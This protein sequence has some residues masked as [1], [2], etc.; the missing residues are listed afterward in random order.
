MKFYIKSWIRE[1]ELMLA[2][3]PIIYS[4]E[5][6]DLLVIYFMELVSDTLM[7]IFTLLIKID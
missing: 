1:A 3:V 2:S 5:I 7:F 4:L 6:M